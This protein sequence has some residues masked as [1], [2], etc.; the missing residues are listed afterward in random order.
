MRILYS[1]GRRCEFNRDAVKAIFA[2]GWVAAQDR[3]VDHHRSAAADA[4]EA[5]S[6]AR[7]N[8]S[9]RAGRSAF[10]QEESFGCKIVSRSSLSLLSYV[11]CASLL[12]NGSGMQNDHAC[13][14]VAGNRNIVGDPGAKGCNNSF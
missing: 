9:I 8:Q 4:R 5:R 7:Q 10:K 3:A 6:E 14:I 11:S 2:C 12:S 13:G 1:A